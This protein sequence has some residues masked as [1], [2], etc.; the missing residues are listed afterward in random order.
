LVTIHGS[1]LRTAN[2]AESRHV[3]SGVALHDGRWCVVEAAHGHI[4]PVGE[5]LD[6]PRPTVDQHPAAVGHVLAEHRHGRLRRR[7]DV[8]GAGGHGDASEVV[9]DV[10]RRPGR[11][12]GHEDALDPGSPSEL[13]DIG[14]MRNGGRADVDHP[15]EVEQEGVEAVEEA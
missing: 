14:R 8:V 4:A 2:S 12:V 7:D 3:R 6:D 11:V 15:I 13:D 5:G 9:G 10:A 1:P